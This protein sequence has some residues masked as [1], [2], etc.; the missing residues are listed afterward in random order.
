MDTRA[1]A[2]SYRRHALFGREAGARPCLTLALLW[3]FVPAES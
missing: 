3:T 2:F 1:R